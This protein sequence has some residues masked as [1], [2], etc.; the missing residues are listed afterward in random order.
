MDPAFTPKEKAAGAFIVMVCLVLFAIFGVIGKGKNWFKSYRIYYI[1]FNEGYNLQVGAPVKLFKADIG[2]VE[3]ITPV[4][5]KVKVKIAVLEDYAGRIRKDVVA[6]VESPTFIGSEYISIKPGSS[7]ASLLPEG[8]ILPS[9]EKK[10]VSDIL[11]EFQVEKTAKK[12]IQAVQDL[13]EAAELLRDRQGPLVSSLENLN[14]S[15]KHLE[16]IISDIEAGKGTIGSLLKSETLYESIAVTLDKLGETI[17][18]IRQASAEAPGTM[19][20]IRSILEAVNQN[21]KQIQT[22]ISD[23]EEGSRDI[24]EITQTTKEGIREIREGVE[25]V[26]RVVRSI[27]ENVLIRSNLPPLKEGKSLDADLRR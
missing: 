11:E 17:E 7:G 10:S 26:D 19:E 27:Q 2:K 22:V 13:S 24:P 1:T 14:R 9:Q 20:S 21:L 16:K 15:T 18:N 23:L 25:R 8:S 6:K 5:D 3:E 12:F 4:E